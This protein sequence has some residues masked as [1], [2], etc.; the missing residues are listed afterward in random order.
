MVDMYVCASVQVWNGAYTS[1]SKSRLKRV[2]AVA[3]DSGPI[4]FIHN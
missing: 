3:V 4:Q 2:V 1:R